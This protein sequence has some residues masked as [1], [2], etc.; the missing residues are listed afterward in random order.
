MA[1]CLRGVGG[2][3]PA[4][5]AA[6]AAAH[7]GGALEAVEISPA[8]NSWASVQALPAT[9]KTFPS[10]VQVWLEYPMVPPSGTLANGASGSYDANADTFVSGIVNAGIAARTVVVIGGG[11][12]RSG[13]AWSAKASPTAF[14]TYWNRVA[15]K[16][17]AAGIRTCWAVEVGQADVADATTVFPTLANVDFIGAILFDYKDS[18]ASITAANRWSYLLSSAPNALGTLAALAKT[19]NRPLALVRW[20]LDLAADTL[21]GTN[22]GGGDDVTF[23][24]STHDFI[25]ANYVAAFLPYQVDV[26]STSTGGGGTGSGPY[27]LTPAPDGSSWPSFYR[28]TFGSAVP[29]ATALTMAGNRGSSRSGAT[30]SN[31]Q[32]DRVLAKLVPSAGPLLRYA[33]DV[34]AKLNFGSA[35]DFVELYPRAADFDPAVPTAVSTCLQA[36]FSATSWRLGYRATTGFVTLASG[37]WALTPG[38]DYG[39]RVVTSTVDPSTGTQTFT[40]YQGTAAAFDIDQTSLAVISN[41]TLT[42]AQVTAAGPAGAFFFQQLGAQGTQGAQTTT[43]AQLDPIPG[44]S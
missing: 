29:S 25:A 16:L 35:N 15:A 1:T 13:L 28:Q 9:A 7:Y 14:V 12:N 21:T 43:I 5:S 38:T 27:A 33:W 44:A 3:D 36:Q 11:M 37:T 40:L 23:V 20:G 2:L 8:D 26:G 10:S 24:S 22:G 31:S 42:S 6:F 30:G 19:K 39:F 34:R 18:D 17:K 4:A 32:T 41:L